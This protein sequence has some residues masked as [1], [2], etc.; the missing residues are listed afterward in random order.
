MHYNYIENNERKE[1]LNEII[2][3]VLGAEEKFVRERYILVAAIDIVNSEGTVK[4]CV[5]ERA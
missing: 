4:S 1:A 5:S 3:Y 2:A